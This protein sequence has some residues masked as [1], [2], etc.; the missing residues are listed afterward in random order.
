MEDFS[1]ITGSPDSEVSIQNQ[2]GIRGIDVFQCLS[3]KYT[4]RQ[5]ETNYN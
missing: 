4:P 5:F 2:L 3:V 1:T